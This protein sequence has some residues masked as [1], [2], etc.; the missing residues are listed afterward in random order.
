[1]TDIQLSLTTAPT[2][3]ALRAIGDRVTRMFQLAVE[4]AVAHQS[5][6]ASFPL[7]PGSCA[8]QLVANRL[9]SIPAAN[10]SRDREGARLDQRPGCAAKPALWRPGGG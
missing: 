9:R 8:E 4:K 6:A 1:M 2:D 10:N 5:D 7:P 3:P